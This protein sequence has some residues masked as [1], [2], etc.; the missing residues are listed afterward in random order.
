MSLGH[1]ALHHII[2]CERMVGCARARPGAP[3]HPPTQQHPPP[4]P[5]TPHATQIW[6]ISW[7]NGWNGWNLMVGP[8]SGASHDAVHVLVQVVH[9][10]A[11][12]LRRRGR[13]QQQAPAGGGSCWGW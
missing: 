12:P 3:P 1:P 13:V 7:L 8:T 4:P 9:L 6:R 10:R 2:A 11:Q 5:H